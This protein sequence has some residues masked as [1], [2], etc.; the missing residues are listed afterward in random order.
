MGELGN[1][2]VAVCELMG[3]DMKPPTGSTLGLDYF[4]K[5]GESVSIDM[6]ALSWLGLK[7]LPDMT[8]HQLKEAVESA[9]NRLDG[10]QDGVLTKDEFVDG[11]IKVAN[12]G[13]ISYILQYFHFYLQI[14]DYCQGEKYSK[15]NL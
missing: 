6:N 8:S 9:F 14:L 11:C 13:N 15:F 12:I 1:V 5:K 4:P 10:N 2:L 7:T 3:I